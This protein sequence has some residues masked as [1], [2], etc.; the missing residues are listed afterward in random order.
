MNHPVLGVVLAAHRPVAQLPENGSVRGALD[1]ELKLMTQA[2][3]AR[4]GGW[5]RR[6]VVLTD[7]YGPQSRN[8]P[9]A[10]PAGYTGGRLALSFR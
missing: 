4:E 10:G 2:S 9:G 1:A 5:R 3:A 6:R 8:R 7:L